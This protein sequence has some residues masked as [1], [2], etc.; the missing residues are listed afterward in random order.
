[1]TARFHRPL[2]LIAFNANDIWRQNYELNKQL[3]GLN[4]DVA[5]L[6][7]IDLKPHE[8]FFVP[9]FLF[10]RTDR[11]PGRKCGTA[12]AAIKVFPT[13]M[14]TCLRFFQLKPQGFAYRLVILK[15]YL[16]Q[17][18]GN[19][20]INADVIEL[21]SFRYKSLLVR[22]LNAKHPFWNSVVSNISGTKLLNAL[23]INEFE[24]SA[25]Q[26]ST[27]YSPAGNGD[28]LDIVVHKNARLTEEIVS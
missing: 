10:Y 14:K 11:F 12:V 6:S 5:L 13:T 27:H 19:T 22:D 1:M 23:Y 3:K 16:Q 24:I 20:W 4:I 25:P 9:N 15:C 8:R 28:V 7:E 21:L 26:C 17:S 18:P 2:K